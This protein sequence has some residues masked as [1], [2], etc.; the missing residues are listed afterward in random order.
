LNPSIDKIINER[1]NIIFNS[2]LA[3]EYDD[4]ELF[5]LSFCIL[6]SLDKDGCEN[7]PYQTSESFI[8]VLESRFNST[9]MQ[10]HPRYFILHKM[11][12]KM[13]RF[14]NNEISISNVLR[15]RKHIDNYSV[16]LL[17]NPLIISDDLPA[18][19]E[20]QREVA[21]GFEPEKIKYLANFLKIRKYFNTEYPATGEIINTHE[22][23]HAFLFSLLA[24]SFI[25]DSNILIKLNN[26]GF[27]DI[28]LK[29]NTIRMPITK[30]TK[31]VNYANIKVDPFS[32]VILKSL[33]LQKDKKIFNIS[34]KEM[35]QW[36][37]KLSC[38]AKANQITL[39]TA[40]ALT[41]VSASLIFPPYSISILSN[42]LKHVSI[43]ANTIMRISSN[44]LNNKK[45]YF[46]MKNI[47]VASTAKA[48]ISEPHKQTK[49]VKEYA[50]LAYEFYKCVSIKNGPTDSIRKLEKM[51]EANK[52]L[53]D[54]FETLRLL[55]EWITWGIKQEKGNTIRTIKDYYTGFYKDL[56]YNTFE[57][58]LGLMS[59]EDISELIETMYLER[60]AIDKVDKKAKELEYSDKKI[61]SSTKI[62][63]K[64]KNFF[65]WYNQTYDKHFSNIIYDEINIQGN[66]GRVRNSI[67]TAKEFQIFLSNLS[68]CDI[69][70][71]KELRIIFI[72]GFFAG[73]RISE[74]LTL[75]IRNIVQ[76]PEPYIYI[77]KIKSVAGR[78]LFKLKSLVPSKYVN[79]ILRYRSEKDNKFNTHLFYENEDEYKNIKLS[80]NATMIGLKGFLKDDKF[81]FHSLRHS[82]GSLL[83]LRYYSATEYGFAEYLEQQFAMEDPFGLNI[84]DK[85]KLL[86]LLGALEPQSNPNDL[87]WNISTIMG[88]AS[89]ETTILNY[90]HTIEYYLGYRFYKY[91]QQLYG[92]L[93]R[94]QILNLIPTI[95]SYK[96]LKKHEWG[97][98]D[99]LHKIDEY[100]T[101][102]LLKKL[103]G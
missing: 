31:N 47:K 8:G 52:D 40:F 100:I 65:D 80:I 46:K 59:E 90:M 76:G 16:E 96:A 24:N 73:M 83:F 26:I 36:L 69:I 70:N 20:L 61:V 35:D 5:E 64:I 18:F 11:L 55:Y 42:K 13:L 66:M 99:N 87:L 62:I 48:N 88:H 28:N 84:Y 9:F 60:V 14:L 41:K 22:L 77:P 15:H 33:L 37:E 49:N 78:R 68:E 10:T 63:V 45:F 103:R 98:E 21:E 91:K 2:K 12:R 53:V 58:P 82:F 94:K 101:K 50:N 79:E 38:H 54:D 51:Y 44:K 86:V 81:V 75:R 67:I 71:H 89:P 6:W 43:D 95:N 34:T 7:L 85:D 56:I 4:E 92:A 102:K 25:S 30:N 93:S 39:K 57:T 27:T 74:I 32:S 17:T 1:L 97:Y 19:T 72:L 3:K 23:Q 29:T